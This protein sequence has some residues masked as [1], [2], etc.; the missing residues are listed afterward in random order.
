MGQRY[1]ASLWGGAMG[2]RYGAA[3]G[4]GAM[5]QRYGIGL[6]GVSTG[7]RYGA[8]GGAMGQLWVFMGQ[9]YGAALWGGAMGLTAAITPPPSPPLW[10]CPYADPI[11]GGG[12]GTRWV[13]PNSAPHISAP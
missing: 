5:G 6:S 7:R 2:Q 9:C 1:G 10:G 3:L 11:S 4:G 8:G 13:S 12:G